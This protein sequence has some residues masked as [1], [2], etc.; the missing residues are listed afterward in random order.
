MKSL[1]VFIAVAQTGAFNKAAQRLGLKPSVISHH[2]NKLEAHLGTRLIYR[3]T[4]QLSLSAQGRELYESTHLLFEGSQR[5]ITQL[6]ANSE[7]PRGT[8][9]ISLPQ[10]V[11]D[12]V[13]EQAIWHFHK[14]YSNIELS[15]NFTDEPVH[16]PSNEIDLAIR[17]GQ[18][19]D[20]TLMTKQLS[21]VEHILVISPLLLDSS[22]S[23]I[24]APEQLIHLP[25]IHLNCTNKAL[26]LNHQQIVQEITPV[27]P[28]ITMNSIHAAF[29]ATIAGIGFAE[30]PPALCKQALQSG[31]LVRLLPN[32][33]LHKLPI[34][35][36]YSGKALHN[37]LIKLMVSHI[38]E[39]LSNI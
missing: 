24:T 12:P 15:L 18:Q 28:H 16:L 30:L 3:S 6:S 4:R 14:K 7:E 27:S 38:D 34:C 21:F 17:I 33:R 36:T 32:W 37:S 39:Y 29:N 23:E 8:L 13:I 9:R 35:A 25:R 20:S 10:F 31:Q 22:I 2:I 11:P 5:V 1:A 26:T 19:N